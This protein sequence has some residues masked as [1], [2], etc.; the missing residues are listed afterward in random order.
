MARRENHTKLREWHRDRKSAAVQSRVSPPVTNWHIWFLEGV[1]LLPNNHACCGTLSQ[2]G[3]PGY[4]PAAFNLFWYT[5]FTNV[6]DLSQLISH[7][8][9]NF[10]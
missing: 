2:G 10:E 1:I 6:A 3:A 7:C 8:I 4:R 9:I 5:L